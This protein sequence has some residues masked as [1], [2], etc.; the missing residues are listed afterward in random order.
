MTYNWIIKTLWQNF[1]TS[2]CGH[3]I[4]ENVIEAFYST[5]RY[6][7]DLLNIDDAYF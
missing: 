7:D 5:S 3:T 6:L 2:T 1:A 4:M